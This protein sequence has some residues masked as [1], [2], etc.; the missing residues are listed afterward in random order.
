MSKTV[1]LNDVAT[2]AGVS[3][4]TASRALSGKA[5]AYRISQATADTIKA[6][7]DRLGFRPSSV[8]RSLR[9]KKSGMIGVIVPDIANPFFAAIAREVTDAAEKGDLHVV[10]ADSQG[11]TVREASLVQKLLARQV[12]ALV[13]CPVGLESDHLAQARNSGVP[14]VLVD[15]TFPKEDFIQVTSQHSQG[16]EKAIRLLT[17]KGHR[18]IG[19]LQG[20]PGTLPN[21]ARLAGA[22]RGLAK[23][24]I[25][26]DS[27]TVA[28]TDYTE[29]SGSLAAKSLLDANPDLTALFA[30]SMLNAFGALK[31]ARELNLRVP[32][33]LSI[34]AFDDSPFADFMEVPITTVTQDVTQL[35]RLAGE[36]ITHNVQGGRG[37]RR[38]LHQIGVEVRERQ[39]ISR[40]KK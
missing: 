12:E 14:V 9:L 38:K 23:A 25:A 17:S 34:V 27:V 7:A 22:K 16:A 30:F 40:I 8:A 39:S 33:D 3:P 21:E 15:R 26:Y 18:Q 28:G 1:T 10:L 36:L 31:V 32:E 37:T 6:A 20:L 5:D 2:E 35:G 19:I 4:S 24:G 29:N 13:V 11:D